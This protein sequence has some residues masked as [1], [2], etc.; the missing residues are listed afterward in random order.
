M[1]LQ[2][3][4]RRKNRHQPYPLAQKAGLDPVRIVVRKEE[5]GQTVYEVLTARFP[6]LLDSKAKDLQ[7]RLAAGDFVNLNCKPYA[8]EQLVQTGDQIFFH[9]ELKAEPT[10]SRELPVIF[11]DE[12]LLVVNKPAN[13]ASIP[14]GEHIRRSALV[15]LRTAY[16]LPKLSPIHRLDKQTAGILVLSKVA[17]ERGKYQQLFASRKVDKTYRA[18]VEI[19]KA[20]DNCTPGSLAPIPPGVEF[21]ER[22]KQQPQDIN[23]N[24]LKNHGDLWAHIDPRGKSAHTQVKFLKHKNLN[25]L[26]AAHFSPYSLLELTPHTGR[27]HQL[28][29]HLA[30]VGLPIVGDE[31]YPMKPPDPDGVRRRHNKIDV[32]N[33]ELELHLISYQMAFTDPITGAKRSFKVADSNFQDKLRDEDRRDEDRHDKDRHDKGHRDEE[34]P[35]EEPWWI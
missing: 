35:G 13:M 18:L 30:M 27:T 33:N 21:L 32:F 12:H 24:I 9:R 15:K 34:L 20:F 17:S 4:A 2:S 7:N 19:G 6:A 26:P 8:K 11:E 31:L 29:V 3:P 22:L 16:N 25:Y 14:R 28:R 10:D 1:E 23:A 5:Q